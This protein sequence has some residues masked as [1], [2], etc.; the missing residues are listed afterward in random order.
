MYNNQWI[1][2]SFLNVITAALHR[3]LYRTE[4]IQISRFLLICKFKIT[5]KTLSCKLALI[6][7]ATV[8]FQYLRQDL[9]SPILGPSVLSITHIWYSIHI[10]LWCTSFNFLLQVPFTVPHK[11]P[12]TGQFLSMR[13]LSLG[14]AF[15]KTTV[16]MLIWNTQSHCGHSYYCSPWHLRTV[17]Q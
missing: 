2:I 9:D 4:L 15:L 17:P 5:I 11:V 10:S 6:L 3:Y 8:N 1:L 13:S 7:C 12:P 14:L 16:S